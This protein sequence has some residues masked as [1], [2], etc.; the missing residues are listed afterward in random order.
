MDPS[1]RPYARRILLLH[2]ALLVA[3]IALVSF[4]SYEVYNRTR[5]QIIAQA[6]SRQELLAKQTASAIDAYY[7]S[8]AAD[9]NFL[10]RS[11]DSSQRIE[12]PGP[13][14]NFPPPPRLLRPLWNQ[15]EGRASHLLYVNRQTLSVIH[16]Y[17]EETDH[18]EARAALQPFARWLRD[19]TQ[20]SVS[21]Y[22]PTRN[23]G[24]NLIAVP[25]SADYV[26]AVVVPVSNVEQQFFRVVNRDRSTMATL[27]DETGVVM[28]TSDLANPSFVAITPEQKEAFD[29]PTTRR[30]HHV[31]ARMNMTRMQP[32]TVEYRDRLT[33][34]EP[35]PVDGRNFHVVI[36]SP[37]DDI[38]AAATTM[39]KRAFFGAIFVILAVTAILLST[40]V[41]LIRSRQHIETLRHQMLTKELDQARAIQL[42]WLPNQSACPPHLRIAAVNQTANHI[43]G[44]FYDWFTLPDGRG[45]VTIGDVTGHGM[46]AAFLMATTQLLIRT[47]LP[48]TP[49][50][51]AC[52]EEV[53]R[54]LCSQSFHGQFVTILIAILDPATSTLSLATAG[55]MPPLLSSAGNFAPVPLEPQLPLGI[56]SDTTYAT[57]QIPLP[58]DSTLLL[59]TDGIPD[60]AAPDH[61]RFGLPRLLSSLQSTPDLSPQALI[62]QTVSSVK[63]FCAG[64]PLSDD[65]TLVALTFTPPTVTANRLTPNLTAATP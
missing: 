27:L 46:S 31:L 2:L 24:A 51:A 22:R 15:L 9:L 42:H 63:S 56:A 7:T 14:A 36:A 40:A 65:L 18:E 55:H 32:G 8:I 49:D 39:F 59:Y 60:A 25:L 41:R 57:E 12:R 64:Q 26:L 52:L 43:S 19:L 61:T 4:A 37:L 17:P 35:V 23:G 13:T 62:D 34:V 30:S 21:P 3:V 45:V 48:R 16:A 6:K 53:N 54:Q 33:T 11:E 10:R 29:R 44:D 50:P 5:D 1:T 47:T 38:T 58:H 20:P 28:V